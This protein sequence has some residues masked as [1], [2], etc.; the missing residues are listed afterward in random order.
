[1]VKEKNKVFIVI[2]GH[3]NETKQEVARLL[4]K[5]WIRNNNLT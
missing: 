4:K 5:Y 2:Y 1:M 3:D